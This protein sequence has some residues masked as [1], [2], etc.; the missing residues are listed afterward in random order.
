VRCG[1]AARRHCRNRS[2][3]WQV[4]PPATAETLWPGGLKVVSAGG[5]RRGAV[6]LSHALTGGTGIYVRFRRPRLPADLPILGIDSRRSQ[7]LERG[8]DDSIEGH[9]ARS[10]VEGSCVSLSPPGP[11]QLCGYCLGRARPPMR[12]RG[13]LTLEQRAEVSL[14]SNQSTRSCGRPLLGEPRELRKMASLL[15]RCH[16]PIGVFFLRR[17]ATPDQL[18]SGSSTRRRALEVIWRD[19]RR[20]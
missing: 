13:K 15:E 5:E 20:E 16:R 6:F 9:G 14:L 10:A 18:V 17:A 1:P 3:P 2:Q 8:P 12:W 7:G 19:G 11:Y 4:G